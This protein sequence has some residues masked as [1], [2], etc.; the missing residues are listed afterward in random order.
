[1]EKVGIAFLCV[2]FIFASC[3][4]MQEDVYVD[5]VSSSAEIS[6]LEERFAVIDAQNYEGVEGAGAKEWQKSCEKLISDIELTVKDAS[7]KKAIVARLY[8]IAG[9]AAFDAGSKGQ[10]KK[11]Y[12]SSQ[13]SFKGDARTL[14]LASR[15]GLE[16]N[17]SEKMQLFSDK[18]LL[19]L[20]VALMNYAK[21][22]YAASLAA[23]DE[24]FLSLEPFYRNAY[25]SLRD[26]SW[27]LKN[28]PNDDSRSAQLLALKN[29]TVMQMLLIA[30]Q[31]PDLLF[32]YTAGKEI[33]DK[34]LY[35]KIAGSGLLNPVSQPLDSENAVSKN[36]LVTRLIAARFLWNLYNQR[37][38]SVQNATKYSA[39]YKNQKRSPVPDVKLNSPD[40]DAVLGC[41]E[42]ELMHLEDGIEFG[43]EKEVSGI[44]FSESA[45]KIK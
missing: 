25:G 30:N 9:C 39:A 40:F 21:Q 20:E 16:S 44:E 17:F 19:T 37:R 27:N 42:N 43:S 23:F 45:G 5:A 22:N 38:N 2:S 31:N 15:L 14:I 29:L 41:V 6:A 24:A 10:A 13:E 18:S 3:A 35:T 1:M 8:A 32:N 12:E 33:S 4:S 28:L 11:Y 7:L 26:T 36:S 34:E